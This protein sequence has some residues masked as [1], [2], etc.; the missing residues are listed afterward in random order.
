MADGNSGDNHVKP[1]DNNAGTP[2]AAAHDGHTAKLQAD[3]QPAGADKTPKAT[4]S[5]TVKDAPHVASDHALDKVRATTEA[6][7][8]DSLT[9]L[10]TAQT[11]AKEIVGYI[12]DGKKD[13]DTVTVKGPDGQ[14]KT[15]K[16]ADRITELKKIVDTECATAV[17]QSNNIKQADVA[18]LL[19]TA[20]AERNALAKDLG[21]TTDKFNTNTIESLKKG[22]TD[23]ATIAKLDQLK[24]AQASVDQYKLW[25]N[26]PAYTRMIYASYKATGLTDVATGMQKDTNG[27]LKPSQKDVLDAVQ[28]L[29]EAGANNKDLRS[30]PL[31]LQAVG[32][33]LPKLENSSAKVQQITTDLTGATA[34]GVKGDKTEQERLLKDAVA[35]ADQ[36]NTA[37]IAQMLRDPRFVAS[38]RN[39]AVLSDLANNVVMAST[40]R[41]QYAQFLSDQG[42]FAEAQGLALRVKTEVPEVMYSRD[43][44]DPNKLDYNQSRF[45]DM[46]KLDASLVNSSTVAPNQIQ[47]LL[48]DLGTAMKNGQV[49]S[50][51]GVKGAHEI[52]TDLYTAANK[53]A[54]DT[55]D[56]M[57]GL[58][59]TQKEIDQRR[60]DLANK[61]YLT[62]DA[63]LLEQKQLDREQ[64]TLQQQRLLLQQDAKEATRLTNVVKLFDA[65]LDVSEDKRDAAKALLNEI[66]ASDPTMAAEKDKDGK[67]T[68]FATLEKGTVEPSWWDRNWRKVAWA[69]AAVAGVAVGALTFWSGPGA[70]V[71][72]AGTTAAIAASF[73]LSV[74][75]GATA[76]GL[77]F[78]GTHAALHETGVVSEKVD[79]LRDFEQGAGAGALG[80]VTVVG[81]PAM[82]AL[83]GVGAGGVAAG[84]AVEGGA[85]A[86]E[87]AAGTV[88]ATEATTTSLQAVGWTTQS[89]RL[90]AVSLAGAVPYSTAHYFATDPTQRDLMSE[91]KT[92]GFMTVLPMLG[93][94]GAAGLRAM[95]IMKAAP[96]VASVVSSA[97]N[98]FTKGN[99]LSLTLGIG[100][101]E[102]AD[103]YVQHL[104]ADQR[105][106]AYA[107][108]EDGTVSPLIAN[109]T[110]LFGPYSATR[111]W[112][113]S[114]QGDSLF[115]DRTIIESNWKARDP[116]QDA[117]DAMAAPLN[118]APIQSLQSVFTDAS[119]LKDPNAPADP[120]NPNQPNP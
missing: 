9:H 83:G 69:G 84:T 66:K 46:A 32:T 119:Q 35:Q 17:G 77:T 101:M 115:G 76:G 27:G 89:L 22:T 5:T 116:G 25:E 38:Q 28:L 58:D 87:G 88:A 113:A 42:R 18:Q 47:N 96:E 118:L 2:A 11:A 59:A 30:N 19:Q 92:T 54:A 61:K 79:A 64:A 10:T 36:T 51:D 14:P 68:F 85:L 70:L 102:A 120:S 67:D 105:G 98:F 117:D 91:V 40:A 55:A 29:N 20:R 93:P 26:T 49:D 99:A 90:G 72:G 74:A 34:A 100:G 82:L 80:A 62:D 3:S 107:W 71:A 65:S 86:T 110:S 24:Q 52:I 109:S 112:E 78:L 104:V 97:P 48:D 53:K 21:V 4:D 94:A 57:K 75:A 111:G 108:Q 44:K 6:P 13:T 43:A 41:L 39:P 12:K 8:K 23:S 1:V 73:G 106:P 103:G 81:L 33:V 37:A 16:V 114:R 45:V 63:R 31:Y 95:G 60:T 15:E 50:K 56:G 7:A